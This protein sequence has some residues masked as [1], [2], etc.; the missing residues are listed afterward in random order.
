MNDKSKIEILIAEDS[1][2]QAEQL[3]YILENHGYQVIVAKNGRIAL[4][5]IRQNSP[6]VVISDIN[7]PEMTGYELCKAIKADSN[8]MHIPVILLTSLS[9]SEDVLEGLICGADYFFTKPYNENHLISQIEKLINGNGYN[10]IFNLNNKLEVPLSN[11]TETISVDPN[12]VLTLLISTY[13]AAMS[14]N[15]DLMKTQDELKSMNELLEELVEKRTA[16]LKQEIAERKKTDVLLSYTVKELQRSNEDLAQFLHIASHDLQEPL[17]V[18]SSFVQLLAKRYKNKLDPEAD[19][20]IDFA[21]EGTQ[22]MQK[23]ILDLIEYSRVQSHS[24][25]F[26]NVNTK[27]VL[28][29]VVLNLDKAIQETDTTIKIGDIYNIHGDEFQLIRLFENLINNSIKFRSDK[30]PEIFISSEVKDRHLQFSVRDNGLGIENQYHEKVF[31][32]CQRLHSRENYAGSGVGL[33]L[34]RRIVEM[35]NGKIWLE[36]TPG[37]GTT[38][39][40]TIAAN[41]QER[42][43]AHGERKTVN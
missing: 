32:V 29:Q 12:R 41:E 15:T 21:V 19:E 38:I 30:K 3:R 24:I 7:M 4:S 20:Y 11:K 28:S 42:Q 25:V 36:S 10:Q 37:E 18:V 6:T 14:K 33:S 27:E 22:R 43:T 13:E 17:R 16:V 35:H 9:N 40:F 2:T 31:D 8:L 23:M 1:P 26:K 5:S 34:C 39:F